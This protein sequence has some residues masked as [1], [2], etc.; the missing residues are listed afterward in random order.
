VDG[1]FLMELCRCGHFSQKSTYD[2]THRTVGFRAE[3]ARTKVV[4]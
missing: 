3:K 1:K 2:G 4:D